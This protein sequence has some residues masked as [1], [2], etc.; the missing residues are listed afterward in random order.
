MNTKTLR[1]LLNNVGSRWQLRAS[2]PESIIPNKDYGLG[3]DPGTE[4]IALVEREAL[5]LSNFNAMAAPDGAQATGSFDWRNKSGV[6][7]V[8]VVKNQP[9]LRD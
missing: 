3:Y 7:F 5:S 2:I 1:T 4:E 8:T 9:E 6:N